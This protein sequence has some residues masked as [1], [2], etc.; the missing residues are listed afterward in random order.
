MHGY[1]RSVLFPVIGIGAITVASLVLGWGLLVV[2]ELEGGRRPE[3]P[4]PAPG[5]P[6]RRRPVARRRDPR[7]APAARTLPAVER[8]HAWR[9]RDPVSGEV[10]TIPPRADRPLRPATS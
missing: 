7:H 8:A 1:D 10:P 4:A 3:S 5:E 9:R 6:A 2:T